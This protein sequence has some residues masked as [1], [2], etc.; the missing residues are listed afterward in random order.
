MKMYA[1]Q[2]KLDRMRQ[3]IANLQKDNARLWEV[4][5]QLWEATGVLSVGFERRGKGLA[6]LWDTANVQEQ[7]PALLAEAG[8]PSG[9]AYSPEKVQRYLVGDDAHG[10]CDNALRNASLLIENRG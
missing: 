2:Q 3:E 6:V 5:G 4:V 7:I 9:G 1:D 10:K 8:G